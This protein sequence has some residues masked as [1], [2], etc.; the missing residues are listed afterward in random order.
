M[1]PVR[2]SRDKIAPQRRTGGRSKGPPDLSTLQTPP[3]S[4]F[5]CFPYRILAQ[6]E[7]ADHFVKCIPA[8]PAR[9]LVVEVFDVEGEGAVEG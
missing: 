4:V 7:V 1:T 3:R 2:P 6:Y 9:V 8:A 5:V